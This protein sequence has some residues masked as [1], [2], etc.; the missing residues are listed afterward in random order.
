MLSG[1]HKGH[2]CQMHATTEVMSNVN[3]DLVSM[4]PA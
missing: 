4:I 1:R 3:I 2:T